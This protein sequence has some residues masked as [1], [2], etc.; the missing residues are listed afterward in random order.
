MKRFLILVT[1]FVVTIGLAAFVGTD[2]LNAIELKGIV[3]KGAEPKK[4]EL[5]AVAVTD[6]MRVGLVTRSYRVFSPPKATLPKSAPIIVVLSGVGA[7]VSVESTRDRFLPYVIADKAELVYPVGIGESWDVGGCCGI[8]R[9]LKVDDVGFLEKLVAKVDP[10]RERPIYLVGYSNGGR[11]AYDLAC[12]DPGLFDA[13]AIAKADPM[14]D[15]VVSKPQNILVISALDDPFVP[16]K[17]GETGKETP[18]ATVQVGRLRTHLA[19]TKESA[20]VKYPGMTLRSWSS[21]AHGKRLAWAIFTIGGH[22]FPPPM[23]NAPSASQ[24][25]WSFFTKT[26]IAPLPA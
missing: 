2:V 15:C 16:F 5:P 13:T 25:S 7:S 24:V 9:R 12:T 14:P 1:A 17:L 22:N 18:P 10:G 21:C 11:M 26:A 20:P 3:A 19:C 4:I 6:S 23:S 8:A